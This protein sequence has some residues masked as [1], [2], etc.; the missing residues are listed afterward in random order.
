MSDTVPTASTIRR[1]NENRYLAGNL[2]PVEQ[3]LTAFVD[4][5]D[6]SAPEVARIHLPHRVPFGFHGNWVPETSVRPP[7]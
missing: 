4:A 3:E 1:G 2:A 6:I 5:E 7:N